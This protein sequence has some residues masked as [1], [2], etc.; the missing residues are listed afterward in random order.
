MPAASNVPFQ[1]VGVTTEASSLES[2]VLR[3]IWE[4]R[5][6]HSLLP[7][8]C[9]RDLLQGYQ[10]PGLGCKLKLKFLSLELSLEVVRRTPNENGLIVAPTTHLYVSPALR[11][12]LTRPDSRSRKELVGVIEA[13]LSSQ[14]LSGTCVL[15]E[16][17]LRSERAAAI[18][19]CDTA[20]QCDAAVL[21]YA[22]SDLGLPYGASG[23][24]IA[25]DGAICAV[26][27]A[28]PAV[29]LLDGVHMVAPSASRANAGVVA[30][31]LREA[32]Q[33]EQIAIVLLVAPD[34]HAVHELVREEASITVQ[35]REDTR[36][37]RFGALNMTNDNT[38]WAE[39]D[40]RVGACQS[41]KTAL[42][43][44]LLWRQTRADTFRALGVRAPVGV[45]LYGPPGT[46][47]TLVVKA[48]SHGA[49]FSLRSV[50]AARLARGEV[51]ESERVLKAA[52]D[53][54]Y[55][56]APC[57]L[58]VDEL[59][60]LFVDGGDAACARL[61]AVL[62]SR[63][64]A[65]DNVVVVGATNRPWRVGGALLRAGRFDRVVHM[66]LPDSNDR[67]HIADVYAM[68]MGVC[69][70][71]AT[72]LR[73]MAASQSIDGFSGADI[74]G[75]CRRAAMEAVARG[76]NINVDD[77][78]FAFRNTKRS[79]SKRTAEEIANWKPRL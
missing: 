70:N 53:D 45:L 27:A 20:S 40:S 15:L 13:A 75:V 63:M 66:P 52:F 48:G 21:R 29:L 31:A 8:G 36:E 18:A 16:T 74:A 43:Q 22:A 30:L 24:R 60:A 67:A 77:V 78:R 73:K 26:R 62:A 10:L 57:V 14:P 64:D 42:Q 47:K 9:A 35:F 39:V 19:V 34:E 3:P 2:A 76:D 12:S 44:A 33:I 59:D 68:K 46:G 25:L 51:G 37:Q 50:D 79:V 56:A 49:G 32:A 1:D 11:P 23:L 6:Q 61:I 38:R 17:P 72:V 58:F 55:T 71:V 7:D 54:A 65:L 5:E 69:E 28:A 4:H 41:A